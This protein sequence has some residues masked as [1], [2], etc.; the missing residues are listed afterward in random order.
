MKERR[1]VERENGEKMNIR[2]TFLFSSHV[3]I[4][5]F[6]ILEI[7]RKREVVE[8]KQKKKHK[9]P[10]NNFL[11]VFVFMLKLSVVCN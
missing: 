4:P 3:I 8:T 1:K 10:S 7:F 2:I 11:F 5:S 9:K 6:I